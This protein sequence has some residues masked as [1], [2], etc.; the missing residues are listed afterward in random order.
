MKSGRSE[1][2]RSGSPEGFLFTAFSRTLAGKDIVTLNENAGQGT[3]TLDFS[4]LNTPVSLNV[5]LTTAQTVHI[6]RSII[7]NSDIAFE[8]AR[9]GSSDDVL[10]GNNANNALTGDGGNDSL[11][12]GAGSDSLIGGPGDDTYGFGPASAAE[13]DTLTEIVGQG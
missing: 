7:L 1:T 5:S 3:D 9:G 8:N 6:D 10:R 2:F 11:N 12:G 13:I 4:V